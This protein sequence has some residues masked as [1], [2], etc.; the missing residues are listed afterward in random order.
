MMFS[1]VGR[2]QE[3]YG[4]PNHDADLVCRHLGPIPLAGFLAD[5]EI[6]SVG[7]RTFMHGYT[8]VFGAFCEPR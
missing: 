5:G 4:V 7:G 2:G 6:A 3:L 1:C 8:S